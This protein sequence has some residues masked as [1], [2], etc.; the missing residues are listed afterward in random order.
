MLKRGLL[1]AAMNLW[2]AVA[3]A[4][5]NA[6]G[7]EAA[8]AEPVRAAA[9]KQPFKLPPGFYEKK[10]GKHTLYCKKDAPVGTRFKSEKCYD[11]KQ[12]RDYL[13]ALQEEKSNI[14]RIRATYSITVR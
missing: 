1:P 12:M 2:V 13:I 10:H 14:D 4:Q 6:A 5:D 8:T 3:L 9:D 7:N 11:D